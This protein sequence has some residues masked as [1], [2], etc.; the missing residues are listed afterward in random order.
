MKQ[1]LQQEELL[2]NFKKLKEKFQSRNKKLTE[3]EKFQN[4]SDNSG[5]IVSV[6]GYWEGLK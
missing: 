1:K 3:E 2:K 5:E 4:N 6:L